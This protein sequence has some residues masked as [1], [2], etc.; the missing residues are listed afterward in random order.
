MLNEEFLQNAG[1]TSG[2]ERAKILG[3]LKPTESINFS[4]EK[5]NSP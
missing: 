4:S 3:N 2:I 5:S 1:T